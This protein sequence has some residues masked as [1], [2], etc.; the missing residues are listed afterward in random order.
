MKSH[1]LEERDHWS[2][3]GVHEQGTVVEMNGPEKNGD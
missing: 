3:C 2:N 1:L